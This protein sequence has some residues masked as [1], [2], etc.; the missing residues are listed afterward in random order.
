MRETDFSGMDMNRVAKYAAD[1]NVYAIEYIVNE[2]KNL[3]K[4][5]AKSYY[6]SGA[7]SEDIIQEGMIGLIKAIKDY[8]PEKNA[9]FR[10]FAELCISRQIL[11]AVKAACAKKHLP[12]NSYISLYKEIGDADGTEHYLVDELDVMENEDPIDEIIRK[13]EMDASSKALYD[14]L[15]DFEMLVLSKYMEG[16]NYQEIAVEIDKPPK[17]ID[18]AI[19]RIKQKASK[20]AEELKIRNS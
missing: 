3:V 1:G 14:R 6:I 18:N 10:T 7:E 5:K 15:S 9:S 17:S 13:E 8:S 4:L 11:T 16:K 20:A 2:F 19:Q 12:L